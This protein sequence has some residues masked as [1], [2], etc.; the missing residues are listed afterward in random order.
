MILFILTGLVI[1]IILGFFI[2]LF[3][4]KSRT[5]MKTQGKYSFRQ[6]RHDIQHGDDFILESGRQDH[7]SKDYK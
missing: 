4:V 7:A 2:S 1:G 6:S 3:I 5:G